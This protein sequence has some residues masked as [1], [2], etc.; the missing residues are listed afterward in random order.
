MRVIF[1]TFLTAT[2]GRKTT[3]EQ[4]KAS[5]SLTQSSL[6]SNAILERIIRQQELKKKSEV[7]NNTQLN[8]SKN[9]SR[10]RTISIVIF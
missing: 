8:H 6:D 4:S 10:D 9:R 5:I 3:K 7:P 1:F 2:K